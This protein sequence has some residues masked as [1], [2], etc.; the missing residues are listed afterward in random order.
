VHCGIGLALAKSLCDAMSLE[1][2]VRSRDDGS[3]RFAVEKHVG[4]R[5]AVRS[6]KRNL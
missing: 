5:A 6:L 4:N 2:T 3:V 1:L